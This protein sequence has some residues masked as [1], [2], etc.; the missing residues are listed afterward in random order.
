MSIFF[1]FPIL[2][3]IALLYQNPPY[4]CPSSSLPRPFLLY[5]YHF[6]NLKTCPS[7]MPLLNFPV[8][9][10]YTS[11][12]P[13]QNHFLPLPLLFTFSSF[14]LI[15]LPRQKP[16]LPLS[17]LSTSPIS[18]IYHV[19]TLPFPCPF[20]SLS[21]PFFSY[22]YIYTTSEPFLSHVAS[23]HFLIRSSH[24]S[25]TSKACP[26]LFHHLH[27]PAIYCRT[28]T[29]SNLFLPCDAMR[30]TVLVIVILY[31]CPS[32]CLSVRLSHSCT[33]HKVRPTIMISS[34]YGSPIILVS[35]DIKFIPKF[36]RD[37]PERGR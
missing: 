33:V 16:S 4:S 3:L 36:E 23:L 25:T 27:F 31:V 37:H 34:S 13:R 30:C 22:I 21:H 20:S 18:Y 6:K 12:E 26:F 1:P 32:V 28:S 14:L 35:G 19:R 2:P 29:T 10:F 17:L 9:S 8:L 7:P 11:H 5:V 24:T 15:P